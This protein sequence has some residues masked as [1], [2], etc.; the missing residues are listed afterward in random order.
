MSVNVE[1]KLNLTISVVVACHKGFKEL[2]AKHGY[3]QLFLEVYGR[4]AFRF[5]F[6]CRLALWWD[7]IHDIV[8]HEHNVLHLGPQPLATLFISCFGI[9]TPSIS[10]W[11]LTP[12]LTSDSINLFHFSFPV[13][14]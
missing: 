2:L 9:G 10:L 13:D 14:I 12:S 4:S 5:P 1:T 7:N 3:G 6:N 8:D 11:S